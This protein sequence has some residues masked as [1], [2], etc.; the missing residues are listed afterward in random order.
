MTT[1]PLKRRELQRPEGLGLRW[2]Y[3]VRGP[4]GGHERLELGEVGLR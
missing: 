2:E 3:G 1:D 4:L